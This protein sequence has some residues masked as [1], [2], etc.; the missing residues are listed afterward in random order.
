MKL[1]E[2][3]KNVNAATIWFCTCIVVLKPVAFLAAEVLW[4][5]DANK[6]TS[7]FRS[8]QAVNGTISI[9]T[10]PEYGKVFL[11]LCHD[12]GNTKARCEVAHFRDFQ[13]KNDGVYWFGWMQKWGPLPTKV[14]KWQVLQQIHLS[15]AKAPVPLGLSVPGDGK[16]HLNLQDP[17]GRSTT[18]W[19]HD[20][21]LYSWH[22]F[23]YHIQ[24]SETVANGWLEL[25]YDGVQ[26]TFKNGQTRVSCAMARAGNT[27]YWKWGVYR[28]GAGG[29]IGDS[30]AYLWHPKAATTYAEV[31][32]PVGA[33]TTAREL[34]LLQDRAADRSPVCAGAGIFDLRG[35]CVGEITGFTMHGSGNGYASGRTMRAQGVYCLRPV[36]ASQ[37]NRTMFMAE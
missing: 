16:M 22:S 7:V 21:P 31:E 11:M 35:R 24:Y 1:F 20:L 33:A 34:V 9:V 19:S 14:G 5:G 30:Y 36:N 37:E 12:N 32:P 2:V 18:V 3:K 15:P 29:P 26:Q 4:D 17:S 23:V 28:S 10:D 6:G 27:S 25:W 8:L 13:E